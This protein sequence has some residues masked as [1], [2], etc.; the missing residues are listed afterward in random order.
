MSISH[1]RDPGVVIA[2]NLVTLQ[3]IFPWL[4]VL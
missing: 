3:Q 4:V 1:H 2:G